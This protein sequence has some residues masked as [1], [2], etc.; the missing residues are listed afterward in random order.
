MIACT[1]H[2]DNDGDQ[3]MDCDDPDCSDAPV[4]H[5]PAPAMSPLFAVVSAGLM[6]LFG[7]LLLWRRR[8]SR[9]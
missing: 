3:L 4:C 9:L 2:F 1:D 6:L 7:V 5:I 8:A